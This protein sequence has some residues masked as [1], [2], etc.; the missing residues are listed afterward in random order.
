MEAEGPLAGYCPG[1][2]NDDVT[3]T[4]VGSNGGGARLSHSGWRREDLKGLGLKIQMNGV[5]VF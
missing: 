1:A 4:R 2:K 5:A 3:W